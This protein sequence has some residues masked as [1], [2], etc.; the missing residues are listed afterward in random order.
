MADWFRSLVVLGSAL[1][2]VVATTMGLAFAIVPDPAA[3]SQED[4]E[5]RIATGTPEVVHVGE[6]GGGPSL[7]GG[8]L[9]VTGDRSGTFRLTRE[10]L[11][12][13]YA[14][15]GD[16]GRIFFEGRP[17]TISRIQFDGLEFFLD[18]GDCDL[19]AGERDDATGVAPLEVRCP[20][21]EDLRD[22]AVLSLEGTVGVAADLLGLRGDLPDSGGEVTVGQ[23]T[24]AFDHAFLDVSPV[25][26]F[27]GGGGFG[28]YLP[29]SDGGLYFAY[30]F[31][32]HELELTGLQLQGGFGPSEALELPEGGCDVHL[33]RI[34]VLNPRVTVFE[35]SVSCAEVELEDIGSVRVDGTLIVDI[36]GLD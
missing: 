9:T 26:A 4:R 10:V 1:V 27:G 18:P 33:R 19:T 6:E 2:A 30:D 13:P 14:L 25:P 11:D 31:R 29:A 17:P 20:E 23:Q 34:G 36:A 16:D 15:A 22:T 35:M 5:V 21:I 3:S 28:T 8:T 32:S 7:L 24:L 12:G